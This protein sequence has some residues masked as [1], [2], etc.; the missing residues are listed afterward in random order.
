MAIWFRHLLTDGLALRRTELKGLAF[1]T[2][3]AGEEPGGHYGFQYRF[4][5][6]QQGAFTGMAVADARA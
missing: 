5:A 3:R 6:E 2:G 1:C 4:V